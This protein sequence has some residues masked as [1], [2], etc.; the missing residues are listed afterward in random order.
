VDAEEQLEKARGQLEKVQVAWFDPVDWS[1]LSIYGHLAL[2]NAVVAASRHLGIPTERSHR[3]K[4]DAAEILHRDHGLPDVTD[5]MLELWAM[6]Q[7]ESY[8]DVSPPGDLDPE[9]V[10]SGVE[11]FVEAVTTLLGGPA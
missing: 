11:E 8:G 7:S 2:E 6:R 10:A 9:T 1:D 5:L 3:S 4:S